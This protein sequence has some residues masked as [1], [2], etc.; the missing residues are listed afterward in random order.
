MCGCGYPAHV[1]RHPENDGYFDVDTA[2]CYAT[3]A[4]EVHRGA[5]GYKPDPGEQLAAVYTRPKDE[6]LPGRARPTRITG[7]AEDHA[8]Q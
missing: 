7:N 5:E 4:I 6:P 8:Q 2:V 1:C 3:A